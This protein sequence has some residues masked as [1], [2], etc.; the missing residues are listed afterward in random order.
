MNSGAPVLTANDYR[1]PQ[2]L[3]NTLDQAGEIIGSS[4]GAGSPLCDRLAAL[5]QRLQRQHLQV[6][7]LGQFKRGKSTFVNALIGG[8]VLPTGVVPL[9]AIPTF[10]SWSEEPTVHVR[11]ADRRPPERFAAAD[12][13]GLR[14]ILSG[15]VTEEANP[16][17]RLGIERV[18]VFYPGAVLSGG[19]VLIDTPG[20]GS[21]LTHNTEAA[22][23][24]LLEC[25]AS[26]FIVSADPPITEAELNYLRRLKPKIGRIFF[27][28]NKVDYL[29]GDERRAV[30]EFLRKVLTDE[31]LIDP[32]STIF[33]VSAKS[34]LLARRMEDREAWKLSGMADIEQQFETYLAT[35]KT[36]SLHDAIKRKTADL[37][38]IAIAGIEMRIKTLEMPIEQLQQSS[39]RFAQAM[40]SIDAERL[41][42]GDLL[43][44]EKR[45]LMHELER[46]IGILRDDAQSRLTAV[47]D[48][49]L[50]QDDGSPAQALKTDLSSAIELIFADAHESFIETFSRQ[51]SNTLAAHRNRLEA[52]IQAVQAN[53]AN[54]FG[55]S[56]PAEQDPETLRL[57][58]EPYWITE[59]IASTLIPD[60]GRTIDAF[61]PARVRRNRRRARIVVEVRELVTRNSENLRW[62]ILRGLDETFRAVLTQFDERL[63]DAVAAI[64]GLI[65][66]ALVQRRDRTFI[67]QPAVQ[68][69]DQSRRKLTAI[70]DLMT[71]PNPCMRI[72]T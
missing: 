15:F 22:L 1:P 3:V 44:G 36:Q 40:E 46:K 52:P 41:T 12:A 58:L 29:V 38:A 64:K 6:A 4:I 55:V 8:A 47:I 56:F 20:I 66:Q 30:V 26:L 10:I 68:R 62:A 27:V 14:D 43:S 35:E 16:K 72:A 9:T 13:E 34:G 51:A 57:P 50:P 45:R 67:A 63:A 65:Q 19:T 69:L 37:L 31:A 49:A 42:L 60:L 59:R 33:S 53:A 70:R 24:V 21:T 11:F 25:D 2:H 28:V 48:K 5:R 17:N 7:V 61:F 32:G 54:A 23:R 18:E 71:A 39:L